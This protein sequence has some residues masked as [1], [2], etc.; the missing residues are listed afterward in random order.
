MKRILEE[1]ACKKEARIDEIGESDLL[2]FLLEQSNLT[3]EQFGD[4]LLGALFGGHE[5]TAITIAMALYFLQDCHK[6]IE[7]LR[8]SL[9]YFL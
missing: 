5:T 3:S 8:V 6:A 2:G 4:L 7:Q 9:P 1:R